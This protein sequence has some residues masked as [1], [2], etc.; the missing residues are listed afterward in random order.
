MAP[1][2]MAENYKNSCSRTPRAFRGNINGYVYYADRRSAADLRMIDFWI[3]RT[4]AELNGKC[5]ITS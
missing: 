5:R 1:E 4:N 3:L 2:R